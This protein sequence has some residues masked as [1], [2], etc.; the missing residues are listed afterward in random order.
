MQFDFEKLKFQKTA[1][2]SSD[3]ICCIAE[4]IAQPIGSA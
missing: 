4:M 2:F 1:L 3:H